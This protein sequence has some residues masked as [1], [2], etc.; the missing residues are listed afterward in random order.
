MQ[1]AILNQTAR[2]VVPAAALSNGIGSL[3]EPLLPTDDGE[4]VA[5]EDQRAEDEN[6]PLPLSSITVIIG[7][8]LL[9]SVG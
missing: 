9:G 7:T 2:S 8:V 5:A 4:G 1:R 3:S 6:S